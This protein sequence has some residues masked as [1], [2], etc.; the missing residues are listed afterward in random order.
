MIE[1]H[2][3]R[4][5]SAK[6]VNYFI[7]QGKTLK[8]IAK[9]LALNESFIKSVARGERCFTVAHV[10][11]LEKVVGTSLALLMLEAQ[12]EDVAEEHRQMY[13]DVL[14]VQRIG[15]I[16]KKDLDTKLSS[17]NR[18]RTPRRSSTS[19]DI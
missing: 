14:N 7:S 5:F 9:W 8:Q 6:V 2:V 3:S 12:R 4:S 18:R 1:S 10:D 13:E 11:R 16:Y 15:A 19:D 17:T